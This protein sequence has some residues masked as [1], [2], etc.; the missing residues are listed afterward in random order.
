MT[1][2]GD[3][4][5]AGEI[6]LKLV[7]ATEAANRGVRLIDVCD[8]DSPFL[9]AAYTTLFDANE[10]V[11]EELDIEPGWNNLVDIDGIKISARKMRTPL[12]EFN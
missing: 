8:A 12:C 1:D 4:Q 7:C 5:E 10:E 11:A 3:E 9:E 6:T 2:I